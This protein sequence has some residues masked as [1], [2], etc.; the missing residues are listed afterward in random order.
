M[1][2]LYVN[3]EY[4]AIGV[5]NVAV[6]PGAFIVDSEANAKNAEDPEYV[7]MV[8]TDTGVPYV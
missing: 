5:R 1:E 7:Y 8:G 6:R 4:S 2:V 3:T